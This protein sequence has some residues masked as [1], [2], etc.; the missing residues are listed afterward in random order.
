MQFLKLEEFT[1]EIDS[2]SVVIRSK[3]KTN[4]KKGFEFV[5]TP[6]VITFKIFEDQFCFM[7]LTWKVPL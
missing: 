5:K 7:Y 4:K 3:K 1:T 2:L 6:I